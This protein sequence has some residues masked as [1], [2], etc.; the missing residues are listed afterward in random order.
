MAGKLST[1]VSQQESKNNIEAQ[2]LTLGVVSFPPRAQ[3]QAEE[4][5]GGL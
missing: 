2:S 5:P 3:Q 1:N 4:R